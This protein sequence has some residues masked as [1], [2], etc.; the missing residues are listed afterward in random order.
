LLARWAVG[1]GVF[2][3]FK[4]DHTAFVAISPCVSNAGRLLGLLQKVLGHST[5]KIGEAVD[6]LR[7][8]LPIVPPKSITE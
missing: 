5:A 1:E 8:E 7:E 3:S 4:K 6:M 2:L